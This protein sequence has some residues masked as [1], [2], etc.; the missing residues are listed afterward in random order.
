MVLHLGGSLLATAGG[1][2]TVKLLR[3]LT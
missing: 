3:A 1:F 2:A